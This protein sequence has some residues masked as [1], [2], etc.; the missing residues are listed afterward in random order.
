MGPHKERPVLIWQALIALTLTSV[1]LA[2]VVGVRLA[3]S[4]VI[5]GV[6]IVKGQLVAVHFMETPKST[7]AWNSLYRVWIVLIGLVLMLGTA[8]APRG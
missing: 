4:V 3:V 8:L 2:E 5:F 7:P 6:A 1:V